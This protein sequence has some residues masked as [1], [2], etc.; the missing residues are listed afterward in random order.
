MVLGLQPNTREG[1][2]FL[3]EGLRGKHL[4]C[5]MELVWYSF[6]SNR[7]TKTV[8]LNLSCSWVCE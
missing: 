3:L 1:D 5:V 7:G 8:F 6:I 4:G 2:A